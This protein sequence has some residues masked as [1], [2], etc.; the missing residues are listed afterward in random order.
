MGRGDGVTVRLNMSRT[1][2]LRS[3]SAVGLA[4]IWAKSA[5]PLCLTEVTTATG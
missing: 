5:P 2:R 3:T 1:S 4:V